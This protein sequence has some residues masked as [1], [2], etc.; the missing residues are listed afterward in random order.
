[1]AGGR[2]T[3]Y[4]P[5]YVKIAQ[6]MCEL[7]AIEKEV[8]AAMG[9][10]V[11]TIHRWKQAYPEFRNAL[12]IGKEPAD[13]RV[14]ESLYHRAL[15]YS[16]PEVDIR[17]IEGKVVQTPI[18]KHYPPDPTSMIFWLKNRR[19][20]Q[21]RE[22]REPEGTDELARAIEIIRAVKPE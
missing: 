11:L 17:V 10:D 4:K 16:H 19:P 1:M 2:P 22:K 12:K 21:W 3:K 18:I 20:D 14:E 8:A 7:G 6:K 9:V 5:E 13:D 15:G